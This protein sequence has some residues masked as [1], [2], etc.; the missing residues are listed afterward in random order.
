M[1]S[2]KLLS[3]VTGYEPS[4]VHVLLTLDGRNDERSTTR[5]SGELR[6]GLYK[7]QTEWVSDMT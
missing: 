4:V 7:I 5:F 1:K 3:A 2:P 6:C